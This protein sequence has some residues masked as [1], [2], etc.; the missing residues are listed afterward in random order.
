M[1][2]ADVKRAINGKEGIPPDQ[3]RLICAGKQLEDSRTLADYN[4]QKEATLH[5]ILRLRG[6]TFQSA[7][8]QDVE[9]AEADVGHRWRQ[10][11]PGGGRGLR[12]AMKSKAA[13][14][15]F[16]EERSEAVKRTGVAARLE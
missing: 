10:E 9:L 2:V 16:A 6:E 14:Y 15:S 13:R 3:Q 5:L 12:M 8:N 4:I 7:L 1:S 11:A